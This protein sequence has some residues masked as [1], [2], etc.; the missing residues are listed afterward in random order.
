ML[1]E[2][3][4]A[5]CYSPQNLTHVDL[6]QFTAGIVSLVADYRMDC[7]NIATVMGWSVVSLLCYKFTCTNLCTEFMTEHWLPTD[8]VYLILFNIRLSLNWCVCNCYTEFRNKVQ[9]DADILAPS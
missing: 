2:L 5:T 1:S 7:F 4:A 9:M 3:V 6:W 8:F